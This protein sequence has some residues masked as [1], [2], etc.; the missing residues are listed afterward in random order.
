MIHFRTDFLRRAAGAVLA[1]CSCPEAAYSASAPQTRANRARRVIREQKRG[2]NL[3]GAALHISQNSAPKRFP[4]D[5][6]ECL[7]HMDAMRNAQIAPAGCGKGWYACRQ[8]SVAIATRITLAALN[9]RSASE[10]LYPSIASPVRTAC[11]ISST[12]FWQPG[13][14]MSFPA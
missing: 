7:R 9:W 10:S 12:F 13:I 1:S 4:F 3:W 2:I 8:I 11:T 6:S 14:C 5:F